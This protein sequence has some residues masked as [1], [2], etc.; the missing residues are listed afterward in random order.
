MQTL[1]ML[2]IVEKL[3]KKG[4][5]EIYSATKTTRRK[6]NRRKKK[7]RDKKKIL[8]KNMEMN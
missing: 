6:K 5:L 1:S 8:S 4:V 7:K 3:K 2:L